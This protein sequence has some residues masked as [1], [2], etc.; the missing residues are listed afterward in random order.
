MNSPKWAKLPRSA[1]FVWVFGEPTIDFFFST[2]AGIIPRRHGKGGQ[3]AEFVFVDLQRRTR[4]K[5]RSLSTFFFVFE[6]G[7]D[8]LRCC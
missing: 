4:A 8:V 6:G 2:A 1:R 7:F 3:R 5:G